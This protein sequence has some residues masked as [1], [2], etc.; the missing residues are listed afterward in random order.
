VC[1]TQPVVLCKEPSQAALERSSQHA[2]DVISLTRSKA[3]VRTV[4]V[5]ERLIDLKN[6]S[7]LFIYSLPV[8]AYDPEGWQKLDRLQNSANL[9]LFIHLLYE[10]SKRFVQ[11]IVQPIV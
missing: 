4:D 9:C 2:F 7:Y 5:V 1:K 3:A 8:G 10:Y 11:P 6:N